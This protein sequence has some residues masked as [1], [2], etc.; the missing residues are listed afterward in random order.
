M[1][2]YKNTVEMYVVD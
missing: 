2:Y 1:I